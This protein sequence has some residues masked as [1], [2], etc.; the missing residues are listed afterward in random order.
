MILHVSDRLSTDFTLTSLAKQI[1][2]ARGEPVDVQ[3]VLNNISTNPAPLSLAGPACGYTLEM[4]DFRG[5]I[6]PPKPGVTISGPP[7]TRITLPPGEG[8]ACTVRLSELYDLSKGGRYF[9]T[10]MREVP[11]AG[12]KTAEIYSPTVIITITAPVKN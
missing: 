7:I 3:F 1:S 5:E 4:Q 8:L 2:V 6:L 11:A 10:A 12:G 9:V